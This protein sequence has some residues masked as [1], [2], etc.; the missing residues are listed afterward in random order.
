MVLKNSDYFHNP[1]FILIFTKN[2]LL[3]FFIKNHHRPFNKR[4]VDNEAENIIMMEG[5]T[6]A[7]TNPKEWFKFMKYQINQD[8]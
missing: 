1:N 3:I 5:Q 7:I 8:F 4:E 2:F 6:T